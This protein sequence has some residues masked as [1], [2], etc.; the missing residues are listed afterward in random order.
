MGFEIPQTKTVVVN[1]T[2]IKLTILDISGGE[3]LSNEDSRPIQC[4]WLASLAC[5]ST[6]RNLPGR[7]EF[8]HRVYVA[9]A[10]DTNLRS[11]YVSVSTRSDR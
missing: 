6:K 10:T 4:L 9:S 3:W 1:C 7:G 8:E 11:N 2:P 5:C